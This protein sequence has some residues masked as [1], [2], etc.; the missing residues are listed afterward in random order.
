MEEHS[1]STS[2]T[3]EDVAAHYK[4]KPEELRLNSRTGSLEK[5]RLQDFMQRFLPSPPAVVLDVGGGPGEHGLWLA[6]RGYKVHLID[7]VPYHI[8]QAEQASS[9]Q[10]EAPLASASV[11]DARSLNSPDASVD[12]VLLFG[13]MYHLTERKDRMKSLTEAYRVLKPGGTLMAIAISRF[14]YAL[15]GLFRGYLDDPEFLPLVDR[16][17]KDGQHVNPTGNPEYF[18]DSFFHNADELKAE[19]REGG[20][21]PQGCFGIEGPGWLLPNFHDHWNDEGRRNRLLKMVRALESE[22]S[23]YGLSAHLMVVGQ[24]S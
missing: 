7:I 9:A 11:G 12:S 15:D 13:P 4:A 3:P 2:P 10:P 14:V 19:V 20:F 24:K 23:L 1:E 16:D 21:K 18:T 8:E 6:K 5:K 17:L 22:P